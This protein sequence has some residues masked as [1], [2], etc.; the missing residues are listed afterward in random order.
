MTFNNMLSTLKNK[1]VKFD[2]MGVNFNTF[3]VSIS[4]NT[5]WCYLTPGFGIQQLNSTLGVEVI[6]PLVL[7]FNSSFGAKKNQHH[8]FQHQ[9][10]VECNHD[11]FLVKINT[12][13]LTL[14]SKNPAMSVGLSGNNFPTFLSAKQIFTLNGMIALMT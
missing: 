11:F 2:T 10:C 9:W 12:N 1:G 3:P 13:D 8:F 7:K 5:S 14:N 6:P 4:E